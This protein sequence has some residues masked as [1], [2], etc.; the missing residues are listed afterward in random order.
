MMT[1]ILEGGFT[2]APIEAAHAFR[3]ALGAMSH[4][5]RAFALTGAQAPAPLSLAAGVLILTLVDG[6]TP[7]HLAGGHDVDALR[8][9]IRFHTGAALVGPE[10]AVFAVGTWQALYPHDRFAIGTPDYPDRAA[11]LIVEFAGAWQAARLSGP[12]IQRATRCDVPDVAAFT[13]NHARYPLG[14]DAFL[15]KGDHVTGLPR[16]TNV[17]AI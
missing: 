11:T 16:S 3:A 4:P 15:T 5:G 9:W 12:G 1:R 6:T 13:A 7:V 10:E 14:W 8:D 17:E 2:D